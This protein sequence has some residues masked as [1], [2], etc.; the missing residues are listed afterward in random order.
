[1]ERIAPSLRGKVTSAAAA[2]QLIHTG[3][4]IAVSGFTSVGYPKAVPME[5]VKS[6]H[7]RELTICVAPPWETRSTGLW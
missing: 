3:D 7:A 1:M 2:A 4:T 5:L 6:G